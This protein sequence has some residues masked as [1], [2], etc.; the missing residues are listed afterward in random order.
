[1]LYVYVFFVDVCILYLFVV[2]FDFTR[3][4]V[5]RVIVVFF[6]FVFCISVFCVV[7]IV[8][9]F[10]YFLILFYIVLY[11]FGIL[12]CV[13][14]FYVFATSSFAFVFRLCVIFRVC[15]CVVFCFMN[16][17][18]LIVSDFL[19]VKNCILFSCFVFLNLLI[20]RAFSVVYS[21]RFFASS[22]R[23]MCFRLLF[24]F[25]SCLL[26]SIVMCSFG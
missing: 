2:A 4:Y 3:S 17:L 7:C 23:V 10:M 13:R 24:L 8:C 18:F 22:G 12:F 20:D 16:V 1:M 14:N 5:V 11:L 21:F 15:N 26:F 6:L 25:C 19:C 9:G